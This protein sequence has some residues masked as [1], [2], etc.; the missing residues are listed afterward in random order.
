MLQIVASLTDDYRGAIY[1]RNMFIVSSLL[2]HFPTVL[3]FKSKKFWLQKLNED[4]SDWIGSCPWNA[5][6]IPHG[7]GHVL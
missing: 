3:T 7:P 1:D 6:A 4:V 5:K 2:S